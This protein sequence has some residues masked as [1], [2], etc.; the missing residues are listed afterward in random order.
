LRSVQPDPDRSHGTKL[1]VRMMPTA[2]PESISEVMRN[3]LLS[4]NSILRFPEP[5]VQV[6]SLDGQ[7]VVI[8]LMFRVADFSTAA[9]AKSELFDLIY[10]HSKAAGLRLAPP[11]GT[12]MMSA[13][14]L[15]SDLAAVQQRTTPL[16]LLDSLP[17][18]ASL[19]EDEKVA[20]AKTMRRRVYRKDDVLIEQGAT[21]SS[22][23]VIRTGVVAVT[24]REGEREIV[25]KLAPGD[26][27]GEGG[28][29]TGAAETGTIRA[30]TFVVVHE[31]GQADLAKLMNDRP[32]MVEE[33]G[34]IL[35]R[36]AESEKERAGPSTQIADARSVSRLVA[37]MR[38]LFDVPHG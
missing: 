27:F 7:A 4:C 31:I 6:T 29:L 13:T 33:L 11:P 37:R 26:C 19:T 30:L 21:L 2:T 14:Q 20:L 23:M 1:D 25:S 10:R 24:C 16:R 32:S 5:T 17:L 18:F 15:Q 8:E 3:V 35:A 12:P 22:L 28:L 9:A 34:S 36:R 38:H